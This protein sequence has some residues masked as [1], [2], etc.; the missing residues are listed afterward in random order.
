M[1]YLR[2]DFNMKISVTARIKH[3]AATV[4]GGSAIIVMSTDMAKKYNLDKR[5]VEIVGFGTATSK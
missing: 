2:S 3:A 5:A 4:D 1:D